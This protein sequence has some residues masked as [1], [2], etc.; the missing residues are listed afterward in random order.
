M[1]KAQPTKA[2]YIIAVA[3]I[4]CILSCAVIWLSGTFFVSDEAKMKVHIA[5]V[6]A[7]VMTMSEAMERCNQDGIITLYADNL[8]ECEQQFG[9]TEPFDVA[10]YRRC[11]ENLGIHIR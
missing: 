6:C 2:S 9:S 3:L 11:M 8:I 10:G 1:T 5:A 7:S 4:V